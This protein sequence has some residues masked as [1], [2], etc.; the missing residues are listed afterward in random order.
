MQKLHLEG[1]GKKIVTLSV[2]LGLLAAAQLAARA[3]INGLVA[4]YNF[5][6]G[7]GTSLTDR[8]GTG[9]TGTITGPTWD[10]NGKFGKALSFDGVNDYVNIADSN[11]L[12]FTTGMTLEAWVK[13][14]ALGTGGNAWRTVLFKQNGSGMT[15]ALYANQNSGRPVGQVN[16]GS[17]KNAT[18]TSQLTLNTWTHLTTTYDGANLRLYVN[19]TL[20]STTAVTGSI[21]VTTGSLRIGGNGVW[22][23]WF[24]GSIDN[25]RLYNRA[26]SASEIQ[27]DMN[28]AV[29]A[30]G[31]DTQAPTAPTNLTQTA[32]TT[33]SATVTWTASTDNV[34]VTGYNLYKTGLPAGTATATTTT[35]NGLTCGTT[36]SIGVEAVDAAGNRSAQTPGSITTTACDSTPPTVSIT[37]PAAGTTINGTVTVSANASDNIGVA[38]VQFKLDGVALSAEDTTAP[39][40][41]NWDTTAGANGSHTLTAVARDNANN[42]TTS[43]AVTITVNNQTAQFVNDTVILGL[44]EPTDAIFA[45]DGRMIIIERLGKI[46][47]VQPGANQVDPTPFGQVQSVWGV[48]ERGLLGIVLDPNFSTNGYYY[49]YY[50]NSNTNKNRVSRFQASGNTT[51]AGSE[52]VIWENDITADIWHQGGDLHFGADGYL[53]ISVGDHLRSTTSQELTSYN[54]K[55]LRIAKDGTV[56][57]DN[58]FYDGN[59]PNK[60]AVWA[61]GLRNPFRFNVDPVSGRMYIADVGQGTTE[62]IDLGVRGANYGWPTCEGTC[63]TPGMTNPLYEYQHNGQGA[64]V[65]GGFVYRGTQFPATYQGNFFFADYAQGWIKRL[66]FDANG[67]Y[68]GVQNFLPDDG[69]AVS[70]GSIVALLQGPDGSLYYVD[71]G[72]FAQNNAGSIKRVRN[73]QANQPPTAQAVAD[74]TT[75]PPSLTVN[76]SSTGSSDPEGQPLSYSWDFGDGTTSTA[77]NPTHIYTTK[78]R[79]TARLTV[80]DGTNATASSPIVI[81]VGTPPT[82]TILTPANGLHFRAGDTINFSGTGSDAEDGTLSGASLSWKQVFHHDNHIHPSGTVTTGNSGS[83]Q[84][85]TSGHSFGSDTSYE[86]ILTVTDSDGIQTS[87][88]VTILPQ[89]V[90]TSF[91]SNPNGMTVA[92]DGINFTTPFTYESLAGFQNTVSVASPQ[93][94]ASGRWDFSSWSDGGAQTHQITIPDSNQSLSVNFTLGSTAPTGLVAAYNFNEGNGGTL[95]D[96]SGNNNNGDLLGPIWNG[97]GK[98]GGTLL[99]DGINDAVSIA[100]SN[101]LDLTTGMTLE[102]WVNPASQSSGSW[103]TVLLKEQ[104]GQLIYAMYANTDTNR[105]SAHVYVNGSDRDTRGTAA[106]PVNTWTHLT[107]TYD[108]S[109]LRLYI[110]GTQ[111]SSLAISGSITTSGG[112]L[113]IG[114]NGVWGE[115]YKGYIDDVRVY[116]RALTAS[117]IQTDMNLPVN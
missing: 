55:I 99:F 6:E 74:T 23:E 8:S 59:G 102:A 80:S 92:V 77:A 44:S 105:P 31:P 116:N 97:A 89:I 64:S 117:E 25:I 83:F 1:F 26:L 5:D 41:V 56:P 65:I 88:S 109:T 87:S 10:V 48:E 40:S 18:G 67:N 114:G 104:P 108:G 61:L 93:F 82:A 66:T 9:N 13:P 2:I 73:T 32:A 49:V 12:D 42:T 96:A 36:Y 110:N 58:P 46:W 81:T 115:W 30:P 17:E 54:G 15:Y 51:V 113:K 94:N 90:T 35:F 71:S 100:D 86:I 103:S 111:V 34:G 38:G 14:T 72:P 69:S 28:T 98:N 75:G 39:Y 107:T 60:D 85:P 106:L 29:S 68:T 21:P 79:Y 45:P 3:D 19:G 24:K 11:S 16:I 20:V 57:T 22:P 52:T 53:Y 62:E 47:V 50:T 7:S 112:V 84:I 95:Y 91:T 37:S 4:A 33:T 78:G 101:S 70:Y 43:T 63:N 76:F 27:T